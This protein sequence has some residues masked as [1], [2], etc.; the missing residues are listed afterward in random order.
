MK[1]YTKIGD[2]GETAMIGGERVKKSCL[3]MEVIGEL[4]ELNAALGI[5][6]SQM[7]EKQFSDIKP[8]IVK[9]QHN[10]FTIGSNIAAL[11]TDLSEVPQINKVEVQALEQLIDR[12]DKDLP[13]L[14]NFVIPGGDQATATSYFA[15]TI[16][17]RAERQL[18][19]LSEK[20]DVSSVIKTYLN[21][22]SDLLFV[23]GRWVNKRT[24]NKEILWQK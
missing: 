4:D 9:I 6:L 16:C 13:E 23:L 5:L 3:E 22:L 8:E 17:R 11:Q 2:N 10:L 21:R 1:I 18:I 20:Y 15:R 7:N 24:G 12:L 19:K 14:K